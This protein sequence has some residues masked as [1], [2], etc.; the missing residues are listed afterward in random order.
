MRDRGPLHGPI[1]DLTGLLLGLCSHRESTTVLSSGSVAMREAPGTRWVRNLA[2]ARA[3][4]IALRQ[5]LITRTSGPH[6]IKRSSGSEVR[7][8]TGEGQAIAVA[9][10]IASMAY[11]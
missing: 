11:L 2:G 3:A 5:I 1:K 8:V 7:T 9:A 4:R 10:T 6:S